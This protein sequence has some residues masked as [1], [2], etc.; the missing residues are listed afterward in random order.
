MSIIRYSQESLHNYIIF[1]EVGEIYWYLQ[2]ISNLKK[3][4]VNILVFWGLR[5][6]AARFVIFM[7]KLSWN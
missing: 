2:K 5:D 1:Y 3:K 7:L 6:A 4:N